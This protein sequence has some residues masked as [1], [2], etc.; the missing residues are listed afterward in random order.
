PPLSKGVLTG[1]RSAA[2][3]ALR[4]R[5]AWRADAIEPIV[6]TVERIDPAAREIRASDGRAFAYDALLLATG[7]RARRLAIPGADLDGVL[8]LRT[9]DDA[10]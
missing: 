8:V 5:A 7:A 9:L 4:D 6:A 10:A 3:C 2:Q 1:E